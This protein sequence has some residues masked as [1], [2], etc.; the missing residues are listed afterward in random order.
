MAKHIKPFLWWYFAW[1]KLRG[2]FCNVAV[3]LFDVLYLILLSF[4][5]VLHSHL[6]FDI[7]PLLSVGYC[8]VYT[9]FILSAQPNA[10]WFATLSFSTIPR[11]SYRECYGFEL[12]FFIHRRFLP[13]ASSPAFWLN[14]Y[15]SRLPWEPAVLHWSLQGF[16]LI[17]KTQ[18]W[19]ICLFDS[20]YSRKGSHW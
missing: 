8:Q 1:E 4:V 9:Q 15:L 11:S 12:T 5:D 13:Y 2:G 19:S 17:L 20:P 6:L 3:S 14:Q 18:I 7:I 10:E 16:I